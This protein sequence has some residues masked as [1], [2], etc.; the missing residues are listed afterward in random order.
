MAQDRRMTRRIVGLL[1]A[2]RGES[3]LWRVR[4]PRKPQG[5]RWK[6]LQVL[7]EA[8]LVG[9]VAGCKS[10]KATKATGTGTK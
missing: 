4:D 8:A 2:R 9:I 1:N 6:R 5:K 3:G 7:L 10:T